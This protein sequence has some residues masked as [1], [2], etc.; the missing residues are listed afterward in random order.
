MHS[1]ARPFGLL[2]LAGFGSIGCGRDREVRV[3]Y[4]DG[5]GGVIGIPQNTNRW[6]HY[7]RDKAAREMARHFPD[8]GYLVVREV[9]VGKGSRTTFDGASRVAEASPVLNLLKV[10][11]L[12]GTKSHG[13]QQSQQLTE[14]HIFYVKNDANSRRK[15]GDYSPLATYTPA[16]YDGPIAARLLAQIEPGAPSDSSTQLASH[17]ETHPQVKPTGISE[18]PVARP[19]ISMPKPIVIPK[20]ELPE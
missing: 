3:V 14:S 18:K 2:I 12:R 11:L 5:T 7:Y 6:P 10:G 9:E 1:I 15:S 20:L 17:T 8:G 19:A 16:A 13:E 4:R